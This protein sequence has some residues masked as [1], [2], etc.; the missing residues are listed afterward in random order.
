MRQL[1][2]ALFCLAALRSAAA[3]PLRYQFDITADFLSGHP[4]SE[5]QNHLAMTDAAP[6]APAPIRPW[7]VLDWYDA[8]TTG[9]VTI[10]GTPAHDGTYRAEF[11]SNWMLAHQYAPT[12]YRLITPFITITRGDDQITLQRFEVVLGDAPTL[13]PRPFINSEPLLV[14]KPVIWM[15]NHPWLRSISASGSATAVPEPSTL[16]LG[17]FALLSFAALRRRK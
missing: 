13:G 4:L 14:T 11:E 15:R 16:A 10:S 8:N 5:A 9:T 12:T 2:F 6:L 17:S 7:G 3:N 1:F